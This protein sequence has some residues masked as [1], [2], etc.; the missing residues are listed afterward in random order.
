M[1]FAFSNVHLIAGCKLFKQIEK[2]LRS[3]CFGQKTKLSSMYLSKNSLINKHSSLEKYFGNPCVNSRQ[4]EF[5]ENHFHK[6]G[7]GTI[8]CI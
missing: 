2:L 5:Y 7:Y 4:L 3:K 6:K 8:N 1:T